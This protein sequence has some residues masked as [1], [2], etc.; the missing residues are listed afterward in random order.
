M[1]LTARP[2]GA[3][4]LKP[5]SESSRGLEQDLHAAV[6]DS[7][8]KPRQLLPGLAPADRLLPLG[9]QAQH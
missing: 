3:A 5:A 8:V 1:S 9:A 2:S 6:S 7:A 4:G